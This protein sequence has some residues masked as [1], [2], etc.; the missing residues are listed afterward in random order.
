[1]F[2][3]NNHCFS[4]QRKQTGRPK[5][6]IP[7]SLDL[8]AESFYKMSIDFIL[9]GRVS[10]MCC[11]TQTAVISVVTWPSCICLHSCLHLRSNLFP[12]GIPT[13]LSLSSTPPPTH[14]PYLIIQYLVNSTNYEAIFSCSFLLPSIPYSLLNQKSVLE[15][16]TS[17]LHCITLT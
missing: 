5:R 8:G 2:T 13:R 7:C 9:G 3:I 14:H 17:K 11:V 4:I 16:N 15:K 1:M 6:N 12:S 10:L